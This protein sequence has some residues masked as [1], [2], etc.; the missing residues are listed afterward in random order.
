M[1]AILVD[2]ARGPARSGRQRSRDVYHL[3]EDVDR[4]IGRERIPEDLRVTALLQDFWEPGP[5]PV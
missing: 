2:N 4:V 5:V 1:A 3:H